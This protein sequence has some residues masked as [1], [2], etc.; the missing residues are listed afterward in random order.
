[1]CRGIRAYK[2]NSLTWSMAPSRKEMCSLTYKISTFTCHTAASY[3]VSAITTAWY[4]HCACL[5]AVVKLCEG[6]FWRKLFNSTS[7]VKYLGMQRLFLQDGHYTKFHGE[8][9]ILEKKE[10]KRH[11]F[12]LATDIDIEIVRKIKTE[13]KKLSLEFR[14]TETSN[15]MT[16]V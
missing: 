14:D 4:M 16:F 13:K 15:S 12:I 10:H 2:L 8:C 11:I 7:R 6:H 9:W 1:M 5:P 3:L